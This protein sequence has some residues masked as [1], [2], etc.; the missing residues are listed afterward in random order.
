MIKKSFSRLTAVGL[1]LGTF[2]ATSCQKDE[3]A[4]DVS[5]ETTELAET[6]LKSYSLN[7]DLS[8]EFSGK[9]LKGARAIFKNTVTGQTYT[10]NAQSA[11]ELTAELPEAAYSVEISGY[12]EDVVNGKKQN[13]RVSVNQDV[14]PTFRSSVSPLLLTLSLNPFADLKIEEIY[15]AG[16]GTNIRD[17]FFKITN[18]ASV[19]VLVDGLVITEGSF[20]NT[21]QRVYTPAIMDTAFAVFSVW[22]V[23]ED[24]FRYIGPS[25]S[26]GLVNQ[27][28]N[29]TGG[30]DLDNDEYYEWF[31]PG[32]STDI[33]NPLVP[34]LEII[35]S[36]TDNIWVLHN[37][38]YR[39]YA[40]G[41][42]GTTKADFLANY[43][44]APTY[45]SPVVGNPPMVVQNTFAFPNAWIADGVNL[46]PTSNWAWNTLYTTIDAGY[47]GI[48]ATNARFGKSVK[49]KVLGTALQDTDNSTNDFTY[50]GSTAVAP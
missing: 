29:H 4:P 30:L 32:T 46:S 47:T 26:L 37:R 33:D 38:G 5:D 22:Q 1:L 48:D 9:E 21:T 43:E 11:T 45:P 7:F 42:L 28:Q 19:S 27:A 44:Y 12:I 24:E 20:L 35:F 23:P 40:I 18:T 50:G 6:N 16:S 36:H 31:T 49:R 3:L 41:Y 14:S 10:I 34:N 13:R 15:F 25:E 8:D 17:Q 2:A 39:S